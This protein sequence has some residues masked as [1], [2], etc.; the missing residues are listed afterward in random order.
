MEYDG[1]LVELER[2]GRQRSE[3]LAG[4]GE[5]DFAVSLRDDRFGIVTAWWLIV[6]GNLDHETHHR[7]QLATYLRMVEE[8]GGARGASPGEQ[9]IP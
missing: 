8:P 3:L 7:G 1:I 6:R 4:M 2:L 5:S 9:V